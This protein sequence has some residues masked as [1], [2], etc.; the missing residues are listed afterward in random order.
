MIVREFLPG[1]AEGVPLV[2][3]EVLPGVAEGVPLVVLVDGLH[4]AVL[5]L[6]SHLHQEKAGIKP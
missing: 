1:V 2:V 3:R 4:A 5:V 6:Q